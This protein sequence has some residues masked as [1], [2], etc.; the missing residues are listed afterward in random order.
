MKNKSTIEEYT[1][2]LKEYV[3]FKSVS[4]DPAF[5][6]EME[7]TVVWLSRYLEDNGFLVRQFQQGRT[8]PVIFASYFLS[9]SLPTV[10]VYG[11]YDV[12]PASKEDGWTTKDP[13]ELV[14]KNGRLVG[15]GVVDNKGQNLIHLCT[16][17]RLIREDRLRYNIK[18]LLEGNEESGNPD[19]PK[20][21][22]KHKKE[23]KADYVLVSDGEI[24]GMNP[25]IEET[26]RGGGNM[27][28]TLTTGKNNLH[29]GLFGGAVPNAG[30]ELAH[31]LYSLKDAKNKV[32]VPG[33]YAGVP[34]VS[35]AQRANNKS[36]SSEKKILALAGVKRIHTPTGLDF[37][38]Q[39]GLM[40]TLE[41]SGIKSGYIG[42][43]F[44]NIVP[45]QAEA[46]IN[47]RV[48]PPQKSS[49]VFK[50]I[51]DYLKNRTPKHAALK[52]EVEDH[53][54]AIALDTKSPVA[55]EIRTILAKVY[56]RNVITKY[57]GGSIPILGDFQKILG[58][59]VISASLGNDDCH[60]HGVDENYRIDL[61]KKGLVFS[62]A[63][64][65]KK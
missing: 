39:T 47:I 2:L 62:E 40:P 31:L 60:M 23:L 11:H 8:N 52:I 38:S 57:V 56:G 16:I 27:K 44:C 20:I 41:V 35:A 32:T 37:Y 18:F 29:S 26:L 59:K 5:R 63:L 4:T 65:A 46:R 64:F 21:L 12:Q 6:S 3:S 53:G 33:F 42:E 55:M 30:L 7:K 49:A 17:A 1:S 28:V 48:V 45:A 61:I 36:I 22:R 14:E 50:L 34:K 58:T 10:L 9:S 15:R 19:L 25:T 54:S 24:V 43:G 51:A 13:F